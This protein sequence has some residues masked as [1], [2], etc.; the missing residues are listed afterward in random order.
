MPTVKV[1]RPD[2]LHCFHCNARVDEAACRCPSCGREF[3][4]EGVPSLR[5]SGRVGERVR[6]GFGSRR[7]G[8]W[9]AVIVLAALAVV[10]G[11]VFRG[12]GERPAVPRPDTPE[13]GARVFD[14]RE[15][16]VG[17]IERRTILAKVRAGLPDDSLRS[18][19]NWLLYRAVDERNRFEGGNL[20]VVW[21][22]LYESDSS[23][24]T[25]WRAMAIWQTPGLTEATRPSG[26]GGDAVRVGGVEYDFSNE[27]RTTAGGGDDD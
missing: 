20:R 21:V 2:G 22:Y 27:M 8:Y 10:S 18:A 5:R 26:I 16:P 9:P 4:G 23:P 7:R 15:H 12:R 17:R 1:R 13:V 19:L 14:T 3:A 24:V 25:D 11:F 6:A